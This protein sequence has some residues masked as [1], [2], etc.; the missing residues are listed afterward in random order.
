MN[1]EG[2][3]TKVRARERTSETLSLRVLKNSLYLPT[4]IKE[5]LKPRFDN[6]DSVKFTPYSTRIVFTC[7]DS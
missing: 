5:N 4:P 3:D 1:G 2:M 7:L 6:L